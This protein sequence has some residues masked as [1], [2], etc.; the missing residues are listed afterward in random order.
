MTVYRLANSLYV[1]FVNTIAIF[2]SFIMKSGSLD[3]C[4]SAYRIQCKTS[5]KYPMTASSHITPANFY[6]SF[7]EFYPIS[8]YFSSKMGYSIVTMV[9]PFSACWI[10][11]TVSGSRD[12]VGSCFPY[13]YNT[14]TSR[15]KTPNSKLVSISSKVTYCTVELQ[16]II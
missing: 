14:C 13:T 1:G 10:Y 3:P 8:Y 2:R 15:S 7:S 4:N 16:K 9:V 5:R 6:D 12:S 11:S